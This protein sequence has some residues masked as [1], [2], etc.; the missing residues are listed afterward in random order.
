LAAEYAARRDFLAQALVAAGF[1]IVVPE[2]AYYILA[3]IR[4]L[5]AT[6]DVAFCDWLVRAVGVAAVP[7]SS[8]YHHP[9]NGRGWVRF[10]FC[11]REE[12]LREAARRLARLPELVAQGRAPAL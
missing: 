7:G 3:D 12:T 11:K 9:E 1:R 5:G 4:A 2:G 6:D 10:T 8:F